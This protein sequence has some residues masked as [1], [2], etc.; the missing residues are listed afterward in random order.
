MSITIAEAV[1]AT[2]M[3]GGKYKKYTD[4]QIRQLSGYE[5][6]V[7]TALNDKSTL[8]TR[9]LNIE[10]YFFSKKNNESLLRD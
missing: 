6:I 4:D 1:K 10:I 2:Y 5:E 7:K 8:L 3:R 9:L